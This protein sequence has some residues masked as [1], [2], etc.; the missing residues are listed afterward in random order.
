M[1]SHL[2]ILSLIAQAIAVLFRNFS[3]V[4]TSSMLFPTSSSIRFT[5]SGFMWSSLIHLD[6]TLVQGDRNGSI[7]VP[8][9]D[10]H[11]LCQHQLFKML[12]FSHW[13]VLLHCQRTSDHRC[14]G[15][16]MGLQLYSIGLLVC[17]YTST[18]QFL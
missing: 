13:M 16:F 14:V 4:P 3:P 7:R 1:R 8:L 2:S 9:H 10:N 6:L 12:S 11:Q 18:M 17:H 5:I 15:S